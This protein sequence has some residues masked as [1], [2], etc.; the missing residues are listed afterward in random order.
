MGF[1]KICV[2]FLVSLWYN[3]YK[4][5]RD[6]GLLSEVRNWLW[7]V[8]VERR[9]KKLCKMFGMSFDLD[10]DNG[11]FSFIGEENSDGVFLRVCDEGDSGERNMLYCR[12]LVVCV[13]DINY[14]QLYYFYI[15]F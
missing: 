6:M 2:Y 1:V 8:R 7:N 5:G 9:R 12:C 10:Y 3:I 15:N 11:I 14:D 13:M 4:G